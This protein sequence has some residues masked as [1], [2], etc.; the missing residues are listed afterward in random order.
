[1][2]PAG[3]SNSRE[4]LKVIVKFLSSSSIDEGRLTEI[5]GEHR[6]EA[7]SAQLRQDDDPERK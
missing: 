1:M 5:P 3:S 2:T 4:G 7:N 6:G